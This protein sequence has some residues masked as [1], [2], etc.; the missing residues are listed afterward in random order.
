M[1]PP[2]HKQ[3]WRVEDGRAWK[4]TCQ[5][6]TTKIPAI[7]N[8]G[9]SA[10]R[11]ARR[12]N[13]QHTLLLH[14]PLLRLTLCRSRVAVVLAAKINAQSVILRLSTTGR[15]SSGPEVPRNILNPFKSLTHAIFGSW[16]DSFPF[17]PR[18]T[19]RCSLIPAHFHI[20]HSASV[21]QPSG[22]LSAFSFFL[23][24]N[25]GRMQPKHVSPD[26][27][28]SREAPYRKSNVWLPWTPSE[29]ACH[30]TSSTHA[31]IAHPPR[32]R[33]RP[34]K[35]PLGLMSPAFLK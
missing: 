26:G 11:G 33:T 31:S 8:R 22:S 27:L 25:P 34:R 18:S 24:L 7:I 15:R 10:R 5:S 2:D 28:R 16:F 12:R 17:P 19:P 29:G 13:F 32:P 30:L 1:C 23:A 3:R 35:P 9:K 20:P 4:T 6:R 21:P 14:S